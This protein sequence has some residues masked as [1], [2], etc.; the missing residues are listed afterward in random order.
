MEWTQ[1][2][3]DIINDP[4][5]ENVRPKAAAMTSDERTQQ[6]LLELMA[7]VDV[8]GR[9]P[10]ADGGLKEKLMHKRLTTMKEMGL[11]Q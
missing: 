5:F 10:T 2:I 7:W 4:M 11:W 9:E 3:L 8:N 6:S 1:E